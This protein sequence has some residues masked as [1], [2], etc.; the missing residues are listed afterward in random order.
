[1]D[2]TSAS[3]LPTFAFTAGSPLRRNPIDL[4]SDDISLRQIGVGH[5][6]VLL[7][8]DEDVEVDPIESPG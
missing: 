2:G 8:L 7:R 1:M 3:S 5:L 6:A 4:R